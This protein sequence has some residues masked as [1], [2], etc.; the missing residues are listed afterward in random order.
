M[1][2][3]DYADV[4][5]LWDSLPGIGLSEADQ[6]PAIQ[7]YLNHNAGLSQVAVQDNRV[8]GA[9][10]CGHDGRRGYL[11]HLAVAPEVQRQGI[12]RA[13]LRTCLERL[14]R[15]GIQKCHIFLIP[16]NRE[17][18]VF[19]EQNGFYLRHDLQLMSCD[20]ID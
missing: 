15:L 13:L 9:V 4:Y 16:D 10:L 1:K 12:G 14:R 17:G 19:W 6:Q 20:L 2:I 3:Q 11:H 7:T 5:R 8:V 18:Q